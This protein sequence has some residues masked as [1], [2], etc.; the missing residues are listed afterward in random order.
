MLEEV[1]ETRK[2]SIIV[3]RSSNL[4]H[5]GGSNKIMVFDDEVIE[6]VKSEF[7]LS[8]AKKMLHEANQ[9][10]EMKKGFRESFCRKSDRKPSIGHFPKTKEQKR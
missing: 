1:P 8:T 7:K 4:R 9:A 10:L 2:N 3:V 5:Q 6:R